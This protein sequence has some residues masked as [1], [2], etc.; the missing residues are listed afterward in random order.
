MTLVKYGKPKL[1]NGI[2]HD[3]NMNSLGGATIP[4][5]A[6]PQVADREVPLRYKG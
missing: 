6:G 3:V 2:V 4:N 1:R 5:P